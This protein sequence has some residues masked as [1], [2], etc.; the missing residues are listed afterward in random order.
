MTHAMEEKINMLNEYINKLDAAISEKN[1]TDAKRL[2]KEIIAVYERE[3]ENLRG[4]LD[5]Y[6]FGDYN[7]P[8]DYIGDASLL[9]AKLM[10]YKINLTSGLYAKFHS[11]D[12]AV[13]VTQTVSQDVTN[14][15][16]ITLEQTIKLINDLPS[17]ELSDQDKEILSGK[18][19]SISVEKDKHKRWAQ[20]GNAL[21]WIAEKGLQVGTAALPYI[22]KAL[23]TGL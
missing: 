12:G 9:K 11:Q 7:S 8:V 15:I 10:N 18:L 19:A 17:S 20:V 23:E 2:Q 3:I 6:K 1:M 22:V 4:E 21:K 14:T 5:N 13:N 16:T